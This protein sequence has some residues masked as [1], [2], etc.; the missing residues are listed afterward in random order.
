MGKSSSQASRV[1]LGIVGVGN[2]GTYHAQSVLNGKVPGCELTAVCDLDAS[3]L[4]GYSQIQTFRDYRALIE[5]GVV[6]ALLVATP[7]YDHVPIGVAALKAG[8]HLMMEKPISVDKGSALKLVA[9][10]KNK[11]QVFGIMFNQRTDPHFQKIRELVRA[12]ELGK[13]QRINW[14]I[15]DWFRSQ[16]YYNSGGWRATWSGEGGGVLINQCVHNID[17]FQWIFGM[18]KSVRAICRMGRYHDIEVEDEVTATWEYANGA[19]GVLVTSTGEAPGVN[20]LEV[21][22]DRGHLVLENGTITFLR[23]EI[24]TSRHILTTHEGYLKPGTWKT[25]IPIRDH[26]EQHIGVLKNFT[27]A[28]LH[29]EKLLASGDEGI[30]SMELINAMLLASIKDKAVTLPINVTEYQAMLK[31]LIRR[32]TFRKK[33]RNYRGSQGNYLLGN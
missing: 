22:G 3:K 12:G 27:N 30:H 4:N 20:R 31:T 13:I 18:P 29:G 16:A 9:A 15:T 32:S 1:H 23:N 26:G 6:D 21:A 28:I 25:E 14:I 10:H 33:T 8:L 11:K 19:T 5:S 7:H 24:P 2:M 17:L